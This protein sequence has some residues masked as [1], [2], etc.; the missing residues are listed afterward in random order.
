MQDPPSTKPRRL[1]ELIDKQTLVLPGAFNALTAIQ[2]ERAGFR[3]VY[4]SGA[5]LAAA[6]GLPDLGLLTMTE[7]LSDSATIANAVSI[8]AL[9]D[10]DT[11]FGTAINVMRTV[12]EFE[13]AGIAGI[14][15]E[16]QENPKKCGHLSGKRLVSSQEMVGTILAATEARRDK[17][18]L[19]VARTDARGVEGLEAAVERA[20]AY[21]EAGA[22]VIFPEALES[23]EEFRAF[24]RQLAKQGAEV[25][26]VANMTEFGKTPYLSV[27]EFEDLGYR[28]VLF[29]VTALRVTTKAVEQVLRDLAN[30][31]S[32]RDLLGQ[33]HTR[34]Q[35]Y[36]LLQYEEYERRERSF[37]STDDGTSHN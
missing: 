31:A 33:M 11:G 6:R 3:A 17:D 26:L 1:R 12:R 4:I 35:L 37:R 36:E 2:I 5:A 29:P 30:H 25:P 9:A 15:L 34:Q 22:D 10:V 18:F 19:I 32:Q 21:V 20:Q 8:P 16:D 24:A 28:L 13:Q 23:A 14:Q 7:V 27:S